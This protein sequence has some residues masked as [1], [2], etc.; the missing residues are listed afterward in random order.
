M[1][2]LVPE[3]YVSDFEVS[4]DFYT[5][6][7]GFTIRYRR[8]HDRF[9]YLER[10]G[11]ELMIEEPV[12]RTWLLDH[13]ERP[14]GRGINLQIASPDV[15]DLYHR[16]R[17]CEIIQPIETKCYR[18]QSDEVDQLQ[19]VLA[20]PDGYLLRFSQVLR[21]RPLNPRARPPASP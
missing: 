8:D 9:A 16:L 15:Q 12:G 1:T 11:A 10:H 19:F 4:L 6:E 20:D 17:G 7:L 14:Y 5:R 21:V 2:V 3:L 13:L 18:R